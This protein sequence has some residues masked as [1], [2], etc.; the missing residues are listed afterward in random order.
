MGL[1]DMH[2]PFSRGTGLGVPDGRD[3]LRSFDTSGEARATSI[4]AAASGWSRAGQIL[5]AEEP[6]TVLGSSSCGSVQNPDHPRPCLLFPEFLIRD[7]HQYDH[8][9]FPDKFIQLYP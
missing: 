3:T 5:E 4:A 9:Y 6:S 2:D 7:W 8:Q 1:L